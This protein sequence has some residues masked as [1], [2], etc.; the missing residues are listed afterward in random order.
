MSQVSKY[1]I[2]DTVYKRILGIFLQSLIKLHTKEESQQ[3]IKDFLTPTEQI[4][5]A[6]RLAIAFLLEKKYDFRTIGRILRVSVT[7]I[8]RVNLM[9][10]I[11]GEGYHKIIGKLLTEEQVKDFL[12]KTGEM[13]ATEFGSVGAGKGVWRYLHHELE[14]KRRSQPF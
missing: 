1:P 12:L 5:L 2:S 6:K 8:A 10:K 14:K 3:F 13:V 7:T 4:M 9:R 11:G